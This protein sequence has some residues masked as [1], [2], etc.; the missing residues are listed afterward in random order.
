MSRKVRSIK[1]EIVDFDL[2]DIKNQMSQSP[3][4]A[5]VLMRESYIDIKRRRASRKDIEQLQAEQAKN[6]AM[7]RRKM[8]EQQNAEAKKTKTTKA[9]ATTETVDTVEETQEQ[10][11]EPKKKTKKRIIKK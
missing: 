9:D 7:V 3:K 11:T 8:K 5:D 6:K 10:Q 1:N 2:F 4:S